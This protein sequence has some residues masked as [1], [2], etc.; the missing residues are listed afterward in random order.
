[1]ISQP[2]LGICMISIVSWSIWQLHM[3]G[4][5]HGQIVYM[6]LV[7]LKPVDL[8]ALAWFLI[9]SIF[10]IHVHSTYDMTDTTTTR[11]RDKSLP[12]WKVFL[13]EVVGLIWYHLDT[14]IAWQHGATLQ[15]NARRMWRRIIANVFGPPQSWLMEMHDHASEWIEDGKRGMIGHGPV[16]IRLLSSARCTR[17]HLDQYHGHSRKI[18]SMISK[19]SEPYLGSIAIGNLL[20]HHII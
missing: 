5:H 10:E 6:K 14:K 18:L 12:V 7:R 2:C 15:N 3:I 9:H 16:D 13:I 4:F 20:D 8:L 19:M 17:S 1:M 11:I